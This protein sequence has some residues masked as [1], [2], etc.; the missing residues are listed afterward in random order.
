MP[1]ITVRA[2]WQSSLPGGDAGNMV[3]KGNRR[4]GDGA[5]TVWESLLDLKPQNLL[6]MLPPTAFFFVIQG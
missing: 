5:V 2:K 6:G 3:I 4:S 1:G